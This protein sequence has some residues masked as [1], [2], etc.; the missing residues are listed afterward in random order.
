MEFF[1]NGC[2]KVLLCG[3]LLCC[4]GCHPSSRR[5]AHVFTWQGHDGASGNPDRIAFIFDG[6]SMGMG[7]AGLAA[8]KKRNF[9]EHDTIRVDIPPAEE[10]AS[11]QYS[12]PYAQS[13]VVNHWYQRKVRVTYY[14]K[15]QPLRMH[16]LTWHYEKG[17]DY[18][19]PEDAIYILDRKKMGK[20]SE[21]IAAI[22][23]KD[24]EAGACVQILF[25]WKIGSSSPS[26]D[27]PYQDTDLVKSLSNQKVRVELHEE[28]KMD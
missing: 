10:L 28:M 9:D 13:G 26:L 25:P 2:A 3:L 22:M 17:R 16:V 14:H 6:K 19:A 27:P 4:M 1:G 12:P 24:I 7:L 11:A 20:G 15:G 8:I 5:T 23:A 18:G 21:G